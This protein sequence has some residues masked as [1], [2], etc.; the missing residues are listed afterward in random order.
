MILASRIEKEGSLPPT[1][2]LHSLALDRSMWAPLVKEIKDQLTVISLDLRGHG[3]SPKDDSFSIE[4]MADDVAATMTDLGHAQ[5]I[6]V[7]LS[8]GGCVAQALASRH[9]GLVT[10]LGLIDTTAWYGPDAPRNW[11]ERASRAREEGMASLAQ[12]QLDRWFGDEFIEGH[13]DEAE[14]LLEV[15]AHNE[16]D[17]YVASC[18][19]MGHFDARDVLAAIAVPTIVIVGELDRATS[20]THAREIASRIPGSVLHVL[21]GAKHL[22]AVEQPAE[23]AALLR[24]LWT[25]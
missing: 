23:V 5:A 19:A 21:A 17:S 8:M 14:R 2:F 20:P 22:T 16:I 15:F 12:F 9:P 25:E 7:G 1:V 3:E 24:P 4:D 11:A 18:H 10:G 6:I 13:R